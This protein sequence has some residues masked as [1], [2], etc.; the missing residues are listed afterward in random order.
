V[1]NNVDL[2]AYMAYIQFLKAL[3]AEAKYEV[4]ISHSNIE[5]AAH[6]IKARRKVLRSFR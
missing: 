1:S 6:V 3:N 4:D 5:T 2:L